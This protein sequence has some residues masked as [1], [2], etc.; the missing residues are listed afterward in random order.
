MSTHATE[1]KRKKEKK[2]AC[3]RCSGFAELIELR[4][5]I[6]NMIF[7]SNVRWENVSGFYLFYFCTALWQSAF[8]M[9]DFNT[10]P[11]TSFGRGAK[12]QAKQPI[13]VLYTRDTQIAEPVGHITNLSRGHGPVDKMTTLLDNFSLLLA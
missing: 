1:G 5:E 10:S 13:R 2:L 9:E 12:Q 11:R 6:K 8:Y 4:V 3:S 7:S